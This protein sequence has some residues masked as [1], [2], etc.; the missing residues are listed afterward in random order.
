M[1][2]DQRL[3]KLAERHE[4][5]TQTV[6][7]IARMQQKNE[8]AHNKNEV[9]IAQVMESVNSLARIAH[10]HENRITG[11]EDSGSRAIAARI[12]SRSSASIRVHLWAKSFRSL[13]RAVRCVRRIPAWIY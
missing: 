12:G 2:I 3:D 10:A 5:L 1:D 7:L 11:L 13:T 4:A 6:E 9:L 8:E